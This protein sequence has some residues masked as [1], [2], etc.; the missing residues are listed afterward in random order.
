MYRLVGRL[1]ASELSELYRADREGAGSVVI[2]LFH[3]KT[4]D[5]AYARVVAD[6]A[7]RLAEVP[8]AGVSRVLQ[9]GLLNRRL[10]IVRED[11]GRYTLGQALTRLNTREV[12]L[13][14]AV[15]IGFVIEVAGILEA[16]HGGGVVHGALTPGNV[17]LG[18]DGAASVADFGA[19]RALLASPGLRKAFGSRGRS[20]YR[21]P[22]LK[23]LA[24]STPATDV[25]ALGA[26]AYELLTLKEPTI[27]RDSLTTRQAEKLPPPSRLVRRVHSRIDAIVMRALET[28]PARRQRT[29]AELADALR[30]FLSAQGGVPG[31]GD[32]KKF[33]EELFP[34]DV[35]LNALAPPP[36]TTSFDLEPIDGVSDLVASLELPE[37]DDRR[38]PFSGGAVDD[39]TSTSDGLPVFSPGDETTNPGQ[40]GAPAD[41]PLDLRQTI[42]LGGADRPDV[43]DPGVHDTLPPV[44]ARLTWEAPAGQ[45]ATPNVDSSSGDAVDRR[46][47][48]IEDFAPTDTLP[49]APASEPPKATSQS[50]QRLG[51]V[52]PKPSKQASER[53]AL[54]T[55]V[56]FAAAFKRDTDEQPPDWRKEREQRRRAGVQAVRGG[57]AILTLVTLGLVGFWLLKS[58]DPVGDLISWMPAPIEVELLK[59]RRPKGLAVPGPTA[60]LPKKLPD[61]DKVNKTVFPKD[62]EPAPPPKKVEPPRPVKPPPPPPRSDCYAPPANVPTASLT[63][64]ARR[65]ATVFLD[66]VRVCGGTNKLPVAPGQHALKVV[67][68]KTKQEWKSSLRLEAGK[69]AKVDPNFR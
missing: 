64:V 33:V 11:S 68:S 24:D 58:P 15:A 25:Y 54:K 19:L 35:V 34:R 44:G 50:A 7:Q 3:P 5:L 6:V 26:M 59:L 39:R 21:A 18:S 46:V 69:H 22:E 32:V 16:A 36:F 29:C 14:P 42:R 30:E 67:D 1:E 2:K 31:R 40:G 51:A 41:Q 56:T 55:L 38:A 23:A 43:T 61:F 28:A 12:V 45:L 57:A 10:A 52:G 53:Q 62:D 20:S 49:P 48:V 13:P 47:R 37:A 27:G 60:P 9:V 63:V 65:P 66:G 4:T 8:Q 17:L